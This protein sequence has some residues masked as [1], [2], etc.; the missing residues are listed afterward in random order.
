M[1]HPNHHLNQ[2]R[3]NQVYYSDVACLPMHRYI[4]V[5][6]VFQL[7]HKSVASVASNVLVSTVQ[8]LSSRRR[9]LHDNF[10]VELEDV[11]EVVV[12]VVAIVVLLFLVV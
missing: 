12:V 2:Q 1:Q 6:V 7:D 5:Y 3:S 8:A 11:T 10:F 4:E 9:F